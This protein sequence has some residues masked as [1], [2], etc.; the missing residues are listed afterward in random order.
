MIGF[1]DSLGNPLA[2]GLTW[3]DTEYDTKWFPSN[4]NNKL[5]INFKV[6]EAVPDTLFMRLLKRK[7]NQLDTV[8]QVL[9]V[10][11]VT[12]GTVDISGSGQGRFQLP[13][14]I[15]TDPDGRSFSIPVEP[16]WEYA[17]EFIKTGAG[18][19][20]V[21]AEMHYSVTMLFTS[22][23]FIGSKQLYVS[24]DGDDTLGDGSSGA[25]FL[26]I[27]HTID[28]AEASSPSSSNPITIRVSGGTFVEEISIHKSGIRIIGIGEST[29]VQ[30]SSGVCVTIT[31]ATPASIADYRAGGRSDYSTLVNQGNAGPQDFVLKDVYLRIPNGGMY[32]EVLGVKGDN[33]DPNKTDFG[34]D[35]TTGASLKFWNVVSGWFTGTPRTPAAEFRNVCVCQFYNCFFNA[36]IKLTN[37]AGPYAYYAG[38]SSLT[39]GF[40]TLD[41]AGLPS[42]SKLAAHLRM[43]YLSSLTLTG[44]QSVNAYNG[45]I[46]GALTMSDT[47]TID[48]RHTIVTGNADI[49]GTSSLTGRNMFIGGNLD[50]E[51]GVTATLDNNFVKGTTTIAAG[52][53]VVTETDCTFAGLITDASNKLIHAGMVRKGIFAESGGAGDRTISFTPA[54]PVGSEICVSLMFED[55]GSGYQTGYIK[56]G[57]LASTG[58]HLM[59]GG[60]G[61]F[62][63]RAERI[64]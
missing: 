38:M 43:P 37:V 23:L 8:Y 21:Y 51:G 50:L 47:S 58:F 10:D 20:E 44:S 56:N 35:S 57:S 64:K 2:V 33:T 46:G 1:A 16:Y 53:G 11:T 32:L 17:I 14:A 54:F 45:Y 25:P 39:L 31:N 27:Q 30:P 9:A 59:T 13:T 42:S 4:D 36:S 6:S 12:M 52:A 55:T 41:S 5:S 61:K 28:I 3:T 60:N 49:N 22:N 18:A 63:W 26:T 48:A 15:T 7:S 40:D 62:H 19:V 29:I 34:Y 24:K